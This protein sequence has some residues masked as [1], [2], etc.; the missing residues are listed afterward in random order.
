[1]VQRLWEMAWQFLKKLKIG[2]IYDPAMLPLGIYSKELKVGART[3][4][5]TFMSIAVLFTTAK[6]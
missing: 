4:I 6:R 2:L 5:C 3:Y 1:M